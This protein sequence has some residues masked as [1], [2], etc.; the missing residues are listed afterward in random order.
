MYNHPG[1]PRTVLVVVLKVLR[2]GG[3]LTPW[4]TGVAGVP[5][6]HGVDGIYTVKLEELP[7]KSNTRI[8]PGKY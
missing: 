2:F 8:A 6:P 3:P 4:N 1:L 7:R 5:S